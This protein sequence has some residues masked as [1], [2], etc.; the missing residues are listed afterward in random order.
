MEAEVWVD[1]S[2]I[3]RDEARALVLAAAG[4]LARVGRDRH[5]EVAVS[6]YVVAHLDEV[7]DSSRA[8]NQVLALDRGTATEP[9]G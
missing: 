5:V 9:E 2:L 3:P 1:G 7:L 8:V 4:R 6:E